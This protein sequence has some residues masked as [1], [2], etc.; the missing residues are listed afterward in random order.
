MQ[1]SLRRFIVALTALVG[2]IALIA[3]SAPAG[4]QSCS[5]RS[6]DGCCAAWAPNLVPGAWWCNGDPQQGQVNV[7]TQAN[8][9]GFCMTMPANTAVS[10]LHAYGWN[11]VTD[12]YS[13]TYKIGSVKTGLR[14]WVA[15]FQNSGYSP[16]PAELGLG[17][18]C[19]AMSYSN[20]SGYTID[21]LITSNLPGC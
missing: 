15:M 4:A 14:S 5:F 13:V 1:K 8:F 16:S 17:S 9:G 6:P 11:N 19:Q 21:S 20:V 18:R 10:D 2:L 3:V 12:C 7:Y